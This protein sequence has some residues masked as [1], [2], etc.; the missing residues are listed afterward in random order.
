MIETRLIP[1]ERLN[2]PRKTSF[3]HQALSTTFNESNWNFVQLSDQHLHDVVNSSLLGKLTL[4]NAL[5]N[6]KS[7]SNRNKYCKFCSSKI[8]EHF[9]KTLACNKQQHFPKKCP[10]EA[11]LTQWSI[12][13]SLS[14]NIG[15][16]T[17]D[18][19]VN[20]NDFRRIE[21]LSRSAKCP[22]KCT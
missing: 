8:F 20:K 12:F 5:A 16:E 21:T 7:Q 19:S 13:A 6:P 3:S 18:Q 2:L 14:E 22:Q 4:K 15:L 10:Q 11:S 17:N 1:W 9:P